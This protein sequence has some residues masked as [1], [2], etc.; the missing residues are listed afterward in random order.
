VRP[1]FLIIGSQKAGTTS[2]YHAL[3]LH[4]EVFVPEK[5]EL[6]FFFLADEYAKG[7]GHYERYFEPAPVSAKARGE[8]SPGYICHPDAPQ[9]IA[10]ALPDAKLVL[11][12]RNP[13]DRAYSQYWDNR[14]QLGE[15]LEWDDAVARLVGGGLFEPGRL[16]YVARGM[17]MAY[18]PRFL[19]RYPRERLLVLVFDDLKADGAAV[20]RRLFEFVGVDP[21]I[22]VPPQKRNV[23]S[24]T[25]NPVARWLFAH[26][27][28]TRGLPRKLRGL[29]LR[30]PRRP[31]KAPPMR[32]ETRARLVEFYRPWNAELEAFLGR[33][34]DWDR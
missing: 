32:A 34:L 3:R 23:T 8:A 10:S 25:V 12:V 20:Q 28:A 33:E 9:R 21:E 31:F 13:I 4:P 15:P 30:G 16:G 24:M 7:I 27:A 29:V 2:L 18:I 1:D 22:A 5:K 6:N 26:P 17:Y 14:R 11:T 19:E